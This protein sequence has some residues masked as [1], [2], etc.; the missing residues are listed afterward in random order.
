MT[1]ELVLL[2]GTFEQAKNILDANG[3]A[4]ASIREVIEARMEDEKKRVITERSKYYSSSGWTREGIVYIPQKGAF[5]VRDS[6]ILAEVGRATRCHRQN[7]E[8][9]LKRKQVEICLED[10]VKIT[11]ETIPT[12]RFADDEL[13]VYLFGDIAGD[14]GKLLRLEGIDRMPVTTSQPKERPFVKQM[15]F[16]IDE[17]AEIDGNDMGLES[18][19]RVFGAKLSEP[20]PMW[21]H[22]G[23]KY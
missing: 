21:H 20:L 1:R 2:D 16:G 15:W 13:T 18:F 3:Y 6:P 17:Q 8:F 23:D 14:Y 12:N 5:L 7:A 4:I 22:L 19:V 10:S 11:A 9:Y